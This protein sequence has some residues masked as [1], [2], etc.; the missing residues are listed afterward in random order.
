MTTISTQWVITEVSSRPSHSL[1]FTN[2]VRYSIDEGESW[3][4]EVFYKAEKIYVYGM[5]TEPGEKT[6]TFTVFGSLVGAHSW[7]IVQ[8]N[9]SKALGKNN[10]P[11]VGVVL[12]LIWYD[13]N[14]GKKTPRSLSLG[15]CL[16]RIAG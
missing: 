11:G 10:M 1:V 16:G 13:D 9:L 7:M 12:R 3:Y 15:R 14:Q 5:M 6:T 2:E 4:S 8:V